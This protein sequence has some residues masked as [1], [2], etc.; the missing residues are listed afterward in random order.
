M[1]KYALVLTFCVMCVYVFHIAADK[2]SSK[3]ISMDLSAVPQT[4]PSLGLAHG[5]DKVDLFHRSSVKRRPMSQ[6]ETTLLTED[7]Q[8][9][10]IVVSYC[11][12]MYTPTDQLLK[13]Y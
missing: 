8:V 13:N 5:H 9:Y 1:Q 6:R 12:G 4:T 10:M 2:E 7:Q 3:K 11:V